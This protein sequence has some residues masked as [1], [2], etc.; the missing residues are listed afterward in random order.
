MQPALGSHAPSFVALPIMA[1]T[2]ILSQKLSTIA[3]SW[4]TDPF[5]PTLQLKNFL[6]SLSAHP[7]LTPKAVEAAKILQDNVVMS[8]VYPDAPMNYRVELMY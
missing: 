8:K 5:R 4:P 2:K 3:V 6:Q 7:N 1:A